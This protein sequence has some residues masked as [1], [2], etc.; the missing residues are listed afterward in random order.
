MRLVFLAMNNAKKWL[1]NQ[2]DKDVSKPG[3]HPQPAVVH[4]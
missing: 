4:I 3:M 2:S 1:H